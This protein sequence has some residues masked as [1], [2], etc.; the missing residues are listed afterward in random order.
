[1]E[2][3]A[4]LINSLQMLINATKTP[5]KMFQWLQ[6][7]SCR[8]TEKYTDLLYE[9]HELYKLYSMNLFKFAVDGNIDINAF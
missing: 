5:S 4:T 8:L 2:L 1:M 6:I 3:F 9:S 7:H